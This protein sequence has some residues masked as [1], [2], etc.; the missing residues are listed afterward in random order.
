MA[1]TKKNIRVTRISQLEDYINSWASEIPWMECVSNHDHDPSDRSILYFQATGSDPSGL[2]FSVSSGYIGRMNDTGA[3]LLNAG[4][5]HFD[6]DTLDYNNHFYYNN[7]GIML[8][9]D[10]SSSW[11]DAAYI[12][13]NFIAF[14]IDNVNSAVDRS[15][16][17]IAFVIAKTDY[18]DVAYIFDSALANSYDNVNSK[19]VIAINYD[20]EVLCTI[21]TF[22]NNYGDGGRTSNMTVLTP[23]PCNDNKNRMVL[24]VY[25]VSSKQHNSYC[26]IINISGHNYLTN[27]KIACKLD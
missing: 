18:G 27:G 23:I 11:I 13:D 24:D 22:D 2:M 17:N 20:T 6:F 14:T 3:L 26:D 8:K 9:T 4:Y 5:N 25:A 16:K 1:Y 19:D 12:S 10:F 7:T 21:P 15:L